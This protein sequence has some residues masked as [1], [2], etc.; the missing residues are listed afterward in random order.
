M[1]RLPLKCWPIRIR[2][3][4]A[5][6]PLEEFSPAGDQPGVVV[7]PVPSPYGMREVTKSAILGSLPDAVAA[8]V[9]WLLR[10]SGWKVRSV[11][12]SG[13]LVP[14]ASE[15]I[16]I[17][18]R[19]F[20]SFGT[21]VTRDYVH[22]LEA[23][24]IPHQLWQARSF[25]QREEVE[26]LRAALNAIEWPDDELS[27]FATLKGGLFAIPETVLFRYRHGIGSFHPFRPLPDDLHADFKPVKEALELLADLHR[28]RNWSSAAEI[29]NTLLEATRAHAAFALR[30]SGNQVLANVYHVC[31]LARANE[32]R[33]GYSF[34]SFVEQLNEESEREDSGEAP[35][36]EEGSEGVR[37]MTVHAAKGLEFPIVIL[38]DM[39]ANAAQ[40]EP[41]KHISAAQNLCALRL[42][43]CS[44]WE[45]IEH[46]D[47]EH[48]RDLA[49][50]VRI[51]YVAAT[52]ARDLLVVPAVGDGPFQKGWL[53]ALNKA[54]YPPAFGYRKSQEAPKCP[55]FGEVTVLSRSLDYEGPEERSVRP[56]LHNIDGCASPVVWWDPSILNLKVQANFGLRQK[57]ILAEGG[58]EAQRGREQ[59]ESWQAARRKS[60]DRGLRPGVNVFLA[61][62]GVEPPLGYSDRV[63]VER[64]GRASRRPKGPR[65][66]SLVHLIMRDVQFGADYPSILPIAETHARLLDATPDEVKAAAQTVVEALRHPL[67]ERARQAGQRHRELPILIKDDLVGLLEAVIDLAFLEDDAWIVVDFKT[68]VEDAQRLPKYR[69]QVGW[70]VHGLEKATGQRARGYLLHI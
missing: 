44:P 51:A 50:G 10:H 22:A 69:R 26:S 8:Y 18:F 46:Q 25:H 13:E 23:R 58:G 45:L 12:G 28:R 55:A 9:D 54:I 4:Q 41:D 15:H 38:A 3:S 34:R 27:V 60:L 66:G 49:E 42:M 61:T 14:I 1:L 56:G 2:A 11:D 70:Y 39:T 35:I 47:E 19:R 6:V 67:L 30:P 53:A 64:V 33:G 59:Y 57:E 43:G 16:A 36:L 17:L 48:K 31:N 29:V 24:S 62:D 21:D 52:R 7:L 68:D 40:R 65:F 20:M 32:L 5:Y 63:Q 37:I